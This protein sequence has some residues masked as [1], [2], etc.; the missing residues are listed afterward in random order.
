MKKITFFKVVIFSLFCF[1]PQLFAQAT[2]TDDAINKK[3]LHILH[4][5]SLK[6]KIGQ[7]LMLDFRYWCSSNSQNNQTCTQDFITMDPTVNNIMS[8]NHIGGVILFANNLKNIAQI[9]TLTD[10]FQQNMAATNN[11]PILIGTDQEGGIV[12]RLPADES[13]TFP[14][15]MAIAAAYL[16]DPKKPYSRKIGK[17]IAK[18]LKAVGIN[19]DF[20]PDV[21]VNVNP[22]NPVINVRSFSDDPQLVTQLGLSLSRAIQEKGISATLKHF[23]GHGDTTTDS[24]I[25]LPIVN[26]SLQEAWQIDLYPFKNIIESNSPDLIMTAHIQYPALD[27]STIYAAKAGKEIIK[28][29]TLSYKIQHDILRQQLA[30]KGVVI[31]DALNMGAIADNFDPT[32]A[33]IKAFEAGDDIA[34]M[35]VAVTQAA[36]AAKVT[37]LIT[38]IEAEVLNGN[39]SENELDQSVLR[40]LTLKLK[41]GLLRPA[42]RSLPQKIA[43]AEKLFANKNQ[44]ELEKSVTDQAIT[45]VQN[46]N[47][48]LPLHVLPGSR[49]H[50]LT[51]WLE[52]GQ[53][54]AE[55]IKIL[56][57]EHQLPS[58]LQVSFAKMADTNLAAEKNAIDNADI[59]ITGD[60]TT[61]S[62]P[63]INSSGATAAKMFYPQQ[64]T[65][66]F[67]EIPLGDSVNYSNK[68][69][70][71]FASDNQID[72]G[73]FAYQTLQYAKSKDKKTIF[74]SLL[75]P[76]DLPNYKDV[77]DAMLVGY[78]FYGYLT[79]GNSGYFR[80]PSMPAVTRIIFG[81]TQAQGKL[82]VN[83]PDPKTPSKIIYSRGFGLTT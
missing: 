22:L 51:P 27:N 47:Q 13:I 79:V 83:V 81:V 65:L 3:A 67:P 58:D 33:T 82:P 80:G 36:D 18:D 40:I 32:D 75:A 30:Y 55:E 31:T 53:G 23:P 64:D 4:G 29:A 43:H 5:M 38:K 52:Q 26:H 28:P 45:V 1:A 49:I 2:S 20:A 12:A 21:D 46:N 78:D 54:I 77:A 76:Y 34:L 69:V 66:V 15:N 56:Q 6:E 9:T 19:T 68:S 41:L 57:A 60:I 42:Q 7:K 16:G 37:D 25:G 8:E 44:R 71:L 74:I 63:V 14:G 70:A 35:P 61:K 59:F 73:Q 17:M 10:A 48:L 24:H 50:I 11:L 62:L 39:I 72:P